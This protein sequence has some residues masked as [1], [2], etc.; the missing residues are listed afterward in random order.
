VRL[1]SSGGEGHRLRA[2]QIGPTEL[3]P[4]DVVKVR[5]DPRLAFV[6]PVEPDLEE[7]S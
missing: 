4:Q 7:A 1:L 6:F 5:L 2:L 3:A